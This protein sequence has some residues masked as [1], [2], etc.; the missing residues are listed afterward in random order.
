MT[1]TADWTATEI[2]ALIDVREQSVTAFATSM[3][4]SRDTVNKWLA[5]TR[6]PLPH[7]ITQLRRLEVGARRKAERHDLPSD[8]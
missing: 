3:H 5:G 7:N 6:S 1:L 8:L 4:V 2:R